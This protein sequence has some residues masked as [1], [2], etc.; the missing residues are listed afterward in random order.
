MKGVRGK[1]F[2]NSFLG[3]FAARNLE[4]QSRE[5]GDCARELK[6]LEDGCEFRV[7]GQV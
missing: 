3:R 2:R 7:I 4:E 6:I 1:R 5:V